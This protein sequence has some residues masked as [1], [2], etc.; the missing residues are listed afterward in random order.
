MEL[1]EEEW[2]SLMGINLRGYFLCS[3]YALPHIIE[4][5]GGGHCQ[6]LLNFGTRWPTETGRLQRRQGWHRTPDEVYG[7]GLRR[8]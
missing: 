2:D 3:K 1:T 7:A 6:L 4:N 5:G 8:A